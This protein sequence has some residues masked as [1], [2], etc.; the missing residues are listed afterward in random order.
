MVKKKHVCTGEC[1]KKST[2]EMAAGAALLGLTIGAMV[3]CPLRGG[4]GDQPLYGISMDD[5]DSAQI[6][7]DDATD[8][9]D[10]AATDDDDS[11]ATD[12]DDAVDG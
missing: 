1:R 12:D 8:D 9:D 10:S 7:D 6:D 4:G 5:D 3:A 11:A 2:A